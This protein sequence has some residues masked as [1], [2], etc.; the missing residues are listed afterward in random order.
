MLSR[1]GTG[2]RPSRRCF[3]ERVGWMERLGTVMRGPAACSALEKGMWQP[4]S[5]SPR[6]NI[7][8]N[9]TEW[10]FALLSAWWKWDRI[11]VSPPGTNWRLG[12]AKAAGSIRIAV[13]GS[14]CRG[15][16]QPL[17]PSTPP[18]P[19]TGEQTFCGLLNVY[20]GV[21]TPGQPSK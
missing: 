3:P 18:T 20:P 6:C 16:G 17:L 11:E 5:G 8:R 1:G 2:A 9:E 14:R 21:S 10:D 19:H 15:H 4:S 12:A 13:A 7:W